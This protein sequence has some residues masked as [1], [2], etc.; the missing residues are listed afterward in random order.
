[1][2]A[3]YLSPDRQGRGI[4]PAVLRTMMD[5]V[6]IPYMNAH[7][8]VATYLEYNTPSRRVFERCGFDFVQF[9]P[10]AVELPP[11]KAG[12]AT[13]SKVGLGFMRWQRA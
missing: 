11:A 9:V 12:G 5:Q 7:I 8:L 1:M 3:V 2:I 10:D 13:G 6:L 4:M